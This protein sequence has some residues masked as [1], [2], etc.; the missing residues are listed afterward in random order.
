MNDNEFRV[1]AAIL[2]RRR[3]LIEDIE[4]RR[5]STIKW[6]VTIN[7][8]LVAASIALRTSVALADCL[9]YGLAIVVG[10][11]GF[12]FML[13]ETNQLKDARNDLAA[14][15]DYLIRNGVDVPAIAGH[16]P[17]RVGFFHEWRTLALFSL[18]IALSIVPALVVWKDWLNFAW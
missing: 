16:L 18:I 5:A 6:A 14:T 4:A 1:C 12:L 9:F 13:Y 11:V 17:A 2:E 3:R 7:M 8:A 15:E 10:L